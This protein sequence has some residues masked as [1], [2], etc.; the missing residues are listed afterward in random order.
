MAIFQAEGSFSQI[1]VELNGW[2]FELFDPAPPSGA[3]EPSSQN[4]GS[5]AK[6]ATNTAAPAAGNFLKRI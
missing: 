1:D 5:A 2:E 3:A 6:P 4:A